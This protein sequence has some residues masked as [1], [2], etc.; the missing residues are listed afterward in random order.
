[1]TRLR[2]LAIVGQRYQ[3]HQQK[4]LPQM[5]ADSHKPQGEPSLLS[6]YVTTAHHRSM[7][8]LG[9]PAPATLVLRGADVDLAQ[10][11]EPFENAAG[12][13]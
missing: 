2:V 11:A 12:P 5:D 8:F 3:P 4:S 13:S 10:S 9:N 7:D 6:L 1:M